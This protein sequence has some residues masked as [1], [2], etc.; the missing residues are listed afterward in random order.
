MPEYNESNHD[1]TYASRADTIVSPEDAREY[2]L[3]TMGYA[4]R[5]EAAYSEIDL[6]EKARTTGMICVDQVDGDMSVRRVFACH[7]DRYGTTA[8]LEIRD[9]MNDSSFCY[10]WYKIEWDAEGELRVDNSN[11]K[12][13]LEARNAPNKD[14]QIIP[15]IDLPSD[16]YKRYTNMDTD[17][18]TIT[19]GRLNEFCKEMQILEAVIWSIAGKND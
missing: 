8:E 3:W 1:R 7:K 9:K 6:E 18:S 13:R 2:Q 17:V 10:V 5:I 16:M 19:L 15:Y 11:Y 4:Q 14:E 12:V